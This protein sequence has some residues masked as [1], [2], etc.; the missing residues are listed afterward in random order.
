MVGDAAKSGSFHDGP[1]AADD[2]IAAGSP[3][4]QAS[5]AADLGI[6]PGHMWAMDG[7]GDDNFVTG[8][9][10]LVGLGGNWTIPTDDDFGSNV[11]RTDGGN[12]GAYW[13]VDENNNPSESLKNQARV[14]VGDY[15][16]VTL[17]E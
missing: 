1:L 4:M 16:G 7:T 15:K 11:L 17:E 9:G 3:G 13:D 14:I 2:V 10:R 5:R 8:G 12:H 6:K